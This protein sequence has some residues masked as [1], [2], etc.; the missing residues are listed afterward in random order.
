VV[1]ILL[2]AKEK[3]YLCAEA[4]DPA[5]GDLVMVNGKGKCTVLKRM[6]M[7]LRVEVEETGKPS[8]SEVKDVVEILNGNSVEASSVPA[9]AAPSALPIP[10]APL[11]P[12][13]QRIGRRRSSTTTTAH[14]ITTAAAA[15]AVSA[16]SH[17]PPPP[18]SAN[19]WANKPKSSLPEAPL[20]SARRIGLRRRST[21]T[22]T[23]TAHSG[24]DMVSVRLQHLKAK[25]LPSGY[26]YRADDIAVSRHGAGYDCRRP[27][28]EVLVNGKAV[29]IALLDPRHK[30]APS[31]LFFEGQLKVGSNV[32]FV[33][34]QEEGAAEDADAGRAAVVLTKN[35][36][37][38]EICFDD[39]DQ[40]GE[41]P[42]G[43]TLFKASDL[44]HQ[45]GDLRRDVVS[46]LRL[47][48]VAKGGSLQPAVRSA[49]GKWRV[50]EV[51]LRA[52][53][54]EGVDFT[55]S[56]GEK[57]FVQRVGGAGGED[58]AVAVAGTVIQKTSAVAEGAATGIVTYVIKYPGEAPGARQ[59]K[60]GKWVEVGVHPSRL[61]SIPQEEAILTHVGTEPVA[62]M[63]LGAVAVSDATAAP[64]FLSVLYEATVETLDATSGS[65]MIR[66]DGNATSEAF[67]PEK[68]EG[69]EI[70]PSQAFHYD[71]GT[72]LFVNCGGEWQ[73]GVVVAASAADAES[74]PGQN[75]HAGRPRTN[76]ALKN[77]GGS[78]ASGGAVAEGEAL[79]FDLNAAN[80]YLNLFP[81]GGYEEAAASYIDLLELRFGTVTDAM[82]DKTLN[83]R[84]QLVRVGM[85]ADGAGSKASSPP[86]PVDDV[87]CL[88]KALLRHKD[89]DLSGKL[90]AAQIV[91][92][93][94]PGTGKTWA[95]MQLLL[96]IIDLEVKEDPGKRSL[97]LLVS[98]QRI[99]FLAGQLRSIAEP[100]VDS[101]GL[102]LLHEVIELE[103]GS[104]EP[105]HAQAL[106]Q[107]LAAR[108]LVVILD[109]FDE[110]AGC[111][112]AVFRLVKTLA[113]EGHSFLLTSRPEGFADL[114][115]AA[116]F[117]SAF[118]FQMD[119]LPLSKEQ[120]RHVLKQQLDRESTFFSN[121][122]S[123]TEARATMD[124]LF[125]KNCPARRIEEQPPI[126]TKLVQ[127]GN[128]KPDDPA[129]N[130]NELYKDAASSKEKMDGAIGGVVDGMKSEGKNVTLVRVR[131]K[132]TEDDGEPKVEQGVSFPRVREKMELKYAEKHPESTG[133]A[134]VQDIIRMSIMCGNEQEMLEVLQR[135]KAHPDL[136]V[137]F[138]Y[139]TVIH[140]N[141]SVLAI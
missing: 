51:Q 93:A 48:S 57:V 130:A 80:H 58:G 86:M 72:E 17:P 55:F 68:Q 43:G 12:S 50:P 53:Q 1:H 7:R 21:T 84:Q 92:L 79:K 6:G 22:T 2:K 85:T 116:T 62:C 39:N 94:E 100:S 110:G 24:A 46:G 75:Y 14:S 8:W 41:A 45:F 118:L 95:S 139:R 87:A 60:N 135:I 101:K 27:A 106:R 82:T 137:S 96:R 9:G 44:R 19:T 49:D 40:K 66:R 23:T 125:L 107:A 78:G 28:P 98:V 127:P 56:L 99:A 83:T 141:S 59:N 34:V 104:A 37:G 15:A 29:G 70:R 140:R 69:I 3:G 115:E 124:K 13:A 89:R 117:T 31:R 74:S 133:A 52:T 63:A 105:L 123:F 97:P 36:R 71:N 129:H 112:P 11:L 25:E 88:A 10:E 102:E 26:F 33:A 91:L 64:G 18:R 35:D 103:F 134:L 61:Q 90:N 114:P 111:K 132:D 120:Q 113:S 42:G 38:M 20:Y 131:L 73:A 121:L 126:K 30:K 54:E 128:W 32:R 81:D 67:D 122:L 76:I 136:R 109:G 5:E 108:R 77:S 47:G 4:M 65:Y 119:L 138:C 16:S